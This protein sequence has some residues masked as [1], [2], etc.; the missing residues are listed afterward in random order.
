MA[1]VIEIR[2]KLNESIH[3]DVRGEIRRYKFDVDRFNIVVSKD[4]M[5]RGGEDHPVD[6]YTIVVSGSIKITMR[7]YDPKLIEGIDPNNRT[8][9]EAILIKHGWNEETILKEGESIVIPPNIPHMF[10]PIGDSIFWEGWTR[11]YEKIPEEQMYRYYTPYRIK[12][13]K[14]IKKYRKKRSD[15]LMGS[16]LTSRTTT[17]I[18]NQN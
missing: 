5:L 8:E 15:F 16:N 10:Q 14:Q 12:V 1:G 3:R 9:F 2:G 11:G 7:K 6:Q 17:H 18:K 4:G 13:D